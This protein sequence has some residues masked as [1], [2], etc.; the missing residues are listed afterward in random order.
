MTDV[1]TYPS[2]PRFGGLTGSATLVIL[3]RSFK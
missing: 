3:D 2:F 1:D